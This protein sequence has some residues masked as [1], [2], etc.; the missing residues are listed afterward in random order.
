MIKRMS[1]VAILLLSA[2]FWPAPALALGFATCSV[3][4]NGVVFGAYDP[5]RDD[6]LDSSGSVTFRCTSTVALLS[7]RIVSF[8]VQL[9]SGNSGSFMPRAMGSGSNAL[10][11]NLYT[12]PTRSTV[13]GNKTGGTGVLSGSFRFPALLT[14]GSVREASFTAYGRVF[15]GQLVPAGSYSDA[16]TVTVLY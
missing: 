2:G 15:S 3:S 16:I 6:P 8:E 7:L 1:L 13:W 10:A 9:S 5:F 4:A 14:I 12:N 11:Y